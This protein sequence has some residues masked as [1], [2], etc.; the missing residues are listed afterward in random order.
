MQNTKDKILN[1][2]FK[3]VPLLGLSEEALEKVCEEIGLEPKVFKIFFPQGIEEFI[4]YYCAKVD[5]EMLKQ[6]AKLP[7]EEMKIREKIG[8][9][10]KIRIAIY[11]KNKEFV[12]KVM[13]H[14]SAPWNVVFASKLVWNTADLIWKHAAQDNSVDYNF[15]TKRTLLVGVLSSTVYYWLSDDSKNWEDTKEFLTKRIEDVLKIGVA[16]RGMINS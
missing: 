1:T 9:S 12:K 7:L 14:L 11:D 3:K 13:G 2:A 5:E 8:E 15:Y 6:I 16:L 4:R 10:V